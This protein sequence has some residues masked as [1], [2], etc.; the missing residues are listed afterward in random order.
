MKYNT[1]KICEECGT[2]FDFDP[3][4]QN[5]QNFQKRKFCSLK[6]S[7][8]NTN[9]RTRGARQL[10]TRYDSFDDKAFLAFMGVRND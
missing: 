6:C 3:A 10:A 9:R 7:G 1:V 4:K 8:R 2:H 5:I